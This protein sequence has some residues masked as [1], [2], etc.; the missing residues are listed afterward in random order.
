M[1]FL[2]GDSTPSPLETNFIQ[3]LRDL[4]EAGAQ[5]LLAEQQLQAES[6]RTADRRRA[7]DAELAKI[8]GLAGLVQRA[9]EE[10]AKPGA[11]SPSGRCAAAIVRSSAD[12]VRAEADRSRAAFSDALSKMDA[13]VA[14]EREAC[15]RALEKLL[16][17][18]DLAG[19]K[20]VLTLQLRGGVRFDARLGM[21]TSYGVEA[22]VDLDVPA[23]HA[24]A[25]PV[26]LDRFVEHLE[27]ET[28]EGSWLSKETKLRPHRFEKYHILEASLGVDQSVLK[29]RQGADGSGRG[30]DVKLRRQPLQ[31]SLLRVDD[32]PK[33][34][35]QPAELGPVDAAKFLALCDALGAATADLIKSRRALAS[36]S[37]DGK[38]LKDHDRP[39][40][41]L[42]RIVSA[43][44]PAIQEI[45]RR[46]PS[47]GE[48]VLKRLV[49][50]D[51]REEIFLSKE[52]FRKKVEAAS[53]AM[54]RVLE[55]L[56]LFAA[57]PAPA[58]P[59]P[60]AAAPAEEPAP[61]DPRAQ[62]EMFH[63]RAIARMKVGETAAALSDFDRALLVR[64]DFAEAYV[65]RATARQTVGDSNGAA[66]D[67]E[68]AL[69]VAP[70]GWK[71]RERI[72]HLL[73][74]ARQQT[75]SKP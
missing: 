69:K 11:D 47:P 6:G 32:P 63:K 7:A 16:L 51:R 28:A 56:G 13:Q 1:S 36:A 5:L 49:G 29:L 72:E 66:S 25:K 21:A 42:E 75:K 60:P 22:S 23:T 46:S 2:F 41:V 24:F 20:P 43:I 18:Q 50:D 71:Y 48:L 15:V 31:V 64:P 65:N 57:A 68:A 3:Y 74:V 14:K 54:L 61:S 55:P 40:A 59:E 34:G 10:A 39:S 30:F 19:S 17:K 67:L 27:M 38:P 35:D 53:P 33:S 70:T 45:A 73:E 4:A 58:R 12:L 8:D 26:R 37:L 9:L 52:E 44:A 62:A